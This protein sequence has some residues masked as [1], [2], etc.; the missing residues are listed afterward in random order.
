MGQRKRKKEDISRGTRR[1]GAHGGEEVHGLRGL[2]LIE[3]SHTESQSPPRFREEKER[4]ILPESHELIRKIMNRKTRILE[5]VI[6][7]VYYIT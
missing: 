5:P 2:T 3:K 7:F 4:R 1:D 6:F